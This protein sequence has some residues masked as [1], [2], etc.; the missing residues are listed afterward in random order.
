[1]DLFFLQTAG[2]KTLDL[3]N[4]NQNKAKNK[5][6]ICVEAAWLCGQQGK[7]LM[8]GRHV[9]TSSRTHRGLRT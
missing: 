5:E 8:P 3:I 6:K 9:Q 7:P 4:K 2:Q 1:M